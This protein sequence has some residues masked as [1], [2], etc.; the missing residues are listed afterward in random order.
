MP[1]RTWFER[2]E[3]ESAME[4]ARNSMQLPTP[5]GAYRDVFER[6]ANRDVSQLSDSSESTDRQATG[7]LQRRRLSS[8]FGDFIAYGL[9]GWDWFINPISFRNRHPDLERDPETGKERNYRSIGAAG[10]VR[11]FVP[12][13]QLKS[14]TPDYRGR[15]NPSPPVND[16]ALA[17]IKDFLFLLQEAAE[18]PIRWMI[19]EE[20]GKVGG[21]YHC[22]L[23]VAGVAHLRRD[24]W[25]RTAFE[26]FGRTR[27]EPFNPAQGAAFYCAKYA[28][29]QLGAIHFGGPA[30]GEPYA[31]VLKPGMTVG[32]FTLASSA[33]MPRN[34]FRRS[35]ACPRGFTSWRSKR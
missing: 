8:E 35:D 20:F 33:E 17:E 28:T 29:K 3:Q 6:Q 31:A 21:R 12:D 13:P 1:I 11:F 7:D 26:R 30:P 34:E 9:G 22:H 4:R 27:I 32:R 2:C 23:L 19:A 14:W 18:Q 25:W 10:R 24:V 5:D 16:L 15:Q